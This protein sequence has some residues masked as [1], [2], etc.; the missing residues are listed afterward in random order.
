MREEYNYD[1][2]MYLIIIKTDVIQHCWM[3]VF[4]IHQM[5]LLLLQITFTWSDPERKNAY[6]ESKAH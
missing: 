3:V 5:K 2:V 1:H 4:R 6:I